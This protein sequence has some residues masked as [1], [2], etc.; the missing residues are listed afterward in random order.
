MSFFAFIGPIG[1]PEMIVILVVGLLVFGNRLPEVGRSL[2][3]G[4]ME[5]KKGLRGMQDEM[6]GIDR[7]SDQLIDKELAS[8][9]RA[10]PEMGSPD[11]APPPPASDPRRVGHGAIEDPIDQGALED[12]EENQ[13]SPPAPRTSVSDPQPDAD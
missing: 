11:D 8:R 1:T 13:S 6:S 9:R 10:I 5:F 7:E 2:G 12:A 4:L 3:R